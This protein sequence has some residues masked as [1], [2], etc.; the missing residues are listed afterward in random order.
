MTASQTKPTTG[1]GKHGALNWNL[2]W[3]CQ[4]RAQFPGGTGALFIEG[5]DNGAGVGMERAVGTGRQEP[6]LAQHLL[7]AMHG[8]G[9]CCT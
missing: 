5:Q 8:A 4:P 9:R 3:N 6:T 2:A 1:L 7:C